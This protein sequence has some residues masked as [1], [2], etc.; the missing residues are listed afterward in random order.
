MSANP[1]PINRPADPREDGLIVHPEVLWSKDH[2][3]LYSGYEYNY[4][5]NFITMQPDFP[6]P[7]RATGPKS[8]PRYIAGQVMEWFKLRQEI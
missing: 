1:T 6:K 8:N 7:I 4:I 5:A 3:A 2:I